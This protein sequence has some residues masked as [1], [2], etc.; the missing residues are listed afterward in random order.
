[1]RGNEFLDKMELIDPA[2]VESAD[3]KSKKKK[4]TWVK[5]GSMAACFCLIAA[6]AI[7]IPNLLPGD[8]S[9]PNPDPGNTIDRTDEPGVYPPAEVVPGFVLDEPRETL[10]FYYNEASA[11][12]D[13][14]RRYIPG[15]FTEELTGEKLAAV[16][17]DRQAPDMAFA[18]YA[19]YDGEGTLLDVVV[20]VNAPF[21]NGADVTVLFSTNEPLR[22]YVIADEPA[23]SK[24]NG[25]NFEVYQWSPDGKTFYYDA[26][27][28]VNGYSV[29]ISYTSNGTSAEKAKID[30]EVIADC[31]TDYKDGKPDLSAIKADVIPEFFDLKLTLSQAQADADFGAYMLGT[32]PSGY[33]EESIRRYKDQNNDYLSGLWTK[34]YDQLS[35]QVT[36]YTEQDA[37]RLTGID[38]TENY[39][40]SLYPIPRAQSVP[41][42]LRE[43][44]DDPIFI[45]EQLTLDAVYAR[46][47][48]SGESGDSSGW[49]MTFS[50]KYNDFIVRVSSKGVEPEWVYQQLIGL[51]ED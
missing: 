10:E 31:F 32:V 14:A 44:V 11:V 41:D 33:M 38:E 35:W 6:T 47:Y 19:G 1:M 30:F 40:L 27:G 15:Y 46:A 3:A 49:R 29:Q 13:A 50:V 43:V 2:F 24:L 4:S 28:D 23:T 42:E 48:K 20:Q 39:D 8:E 25:H 51:L 17:P 26:F 12:V 18:G 22:C 37:N 21:L 9:V 34:G 45:A 7:A 16:I 36:S 5:W